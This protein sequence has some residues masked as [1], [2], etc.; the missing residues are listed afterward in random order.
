MANRYFRLGIALL[1]VG[2]WKKVKAIRVY[3]GNILH[4][5]FYNPNGGKKVHLTVDG[6]KID[7]NLVPDFNDGCEHTVSVRLY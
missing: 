3:R 4:I 6:K 5:E 7:G 2:N 1:L